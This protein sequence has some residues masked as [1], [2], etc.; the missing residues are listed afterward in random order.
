MEA[1]KTKGLPPDEYGLER[2]AAIKSVKT[3]WLQ[4]KITKIG[5]SKQVV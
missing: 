2:E 5:N 4:S 1:K 3:S